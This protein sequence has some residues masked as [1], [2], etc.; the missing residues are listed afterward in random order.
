MPVFEY[1]AVDQTGES[2]RG[3]ENAK[4]IAD[5]TRR[6]RRRNVT[7]VDIR[8]SKSRWDKVADFLGYGQKIP[9]YPVAV[10][11]RQL[12]T[13]LKA[14]V[15]LSSSLDNLSRQGL[16]AKLDRAMFEIQRDIRVGKTMA[17]AFEDQGSKFPAL[18]APMIRAGEA[19]G[20]LDEMLERLA[21]D[22]ERDL[23]LLRAWK[24]AASYPLVLFAICG[25]LTLGLITY[26]FP[27]FIRMFRGLDVELPVVTRALITVTET[28]GNPVVIGPIILGLIVG[29]FLLE[30]HFQTPVGR[31]QRDWLKLELP[32]FGNLSTKISLSRVARILGTLLE[33]GIPALTALRIAGLA[34]ENWII[35]DALERIAFEMKSGA[36]LSKRLEDSPLFPRVFVQLVESGEE[37]GELSLMLHRLGDFFEEESR[38][39]LASFTTLIEPAMI[40]FMGGVVTFVLVAVFQPVYQLMELF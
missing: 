34:C 39:A 21:N 40:L 9:L 12:A 10:L 30:K 29:A 37:S 36:S 17:Q 15:P 22:L 38:L 31:R 25:V 19:S 8:E 7:I 35:R 24:Q 11:I 14:N 6:L 28:V 5:V 20:R 16:N 33:S 26:V 13:M 23:A 18:T 2:L 32:Y 27:T 3:Y 1:L 4:S